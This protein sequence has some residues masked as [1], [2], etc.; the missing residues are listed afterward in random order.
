[1]EECEFK[2]NESSVDGGALALWQNSTAEISDCRFDSNWS[3]QKRGHSIYCEMEMQLKTL[4]EINYINLSKDDD[5]VNV[6]IYD[7]NTKKTK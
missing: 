6:F 2:R 5:P 7:L 4:N 3:S 1:M